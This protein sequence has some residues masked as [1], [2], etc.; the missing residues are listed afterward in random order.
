MLHQSRFVPGVEAN[1][2]LELEHCSKHELVERLT[3][4]WDIGP[5]E[6]LHNLVDTKEK[7]VVAEILYFFLHFLSP[8]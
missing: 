3:W 7:V 2:F 1:P 8:F 5:S 4:S 6:A